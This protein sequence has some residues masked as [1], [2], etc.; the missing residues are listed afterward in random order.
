MRLAV[1]VTLTE[2]H[3]FSEA[4]IPSADLL[5]CIGVETEPIAT[6]PRQSAGD[7]LGVRHVVRARPPTAGWQVESQ[8]P[9]HAV[10][11]GEAGTV[12]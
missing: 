8:R 12:N 10:L 4:D 5:D 6:G 1:R 9:N 2:R 7:R 11:P 3:Y